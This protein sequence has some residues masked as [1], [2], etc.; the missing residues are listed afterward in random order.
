MSRAAT[1]KS[2]DGPAIILVGEGKKDE[3][4]HM[5]THEYL[6]APPGTV[7]AP[8][9]RNEKPSMAT[10]I[11]A[12][13]RQLKRSGYKE[14]S[15][16]H[17]VMEAA[18]GMRVAASGTVTREKAREI[19]HDGTVHGKPLTKKQRGFFGARASGAKLRRA[20]RGWA[21]SPDGQKKWFAVIPAGWTPV[22]APTATPTPTPEPTPTPNPTP[23][24]AQPGDPNYI[25][26]VGQPGITQ[27]GKGSLFDPFG[28]GSPAIKNLFSKGLPTYA[29]SNKLSPT[30][31]GLLESALS[32]GKIDPADFWERIRRD[33]EGFNPQV[34]SGATARFGRLF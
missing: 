23:G 2:V 5:G 15:S 16:M 27:M 13:K 17:K 18:A 22:G 29:Q 21:T 11:A 14:G 32:A 9:R 26:I 28:G 25:D 8:G 3:G 24:E 1:G 12:I 7:V 33:Y 20:A 30:Q 6:L 31:K 34:Q 19:L 10:A 4:V